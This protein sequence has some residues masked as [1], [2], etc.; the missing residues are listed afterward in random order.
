MDPQLDEIRREKL[1][2]AHDVLDVPR[3]QFLVAAEAW[4]QCR[5]GELGPRRFGIQSADCYGL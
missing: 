3:D 5:A 2:V 4:K 1:S